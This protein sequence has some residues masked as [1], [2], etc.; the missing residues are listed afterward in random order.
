MCLYHKPL[1][2]LHSGHVMENNST[3]CFGDDMGFLIAYMLP[4][5]FV[6]LLSKTLPYNKMYLNKF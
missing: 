2:I 5:L 4:M 3:N 6:Q 1:A